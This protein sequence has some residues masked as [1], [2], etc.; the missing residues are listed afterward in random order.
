MAE[1]KPQSLRKSTVKSRKS[2]TKQSKT[3]KKKQSKTDKK[4][5]SK[6]DKKKRKPIPNTDV[7]TGLNSVAKF[8]FIQSI[9]SG[10]ASA[11]RDQI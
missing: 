7:D 1:D 9:I 6:T 11:I 10:I 2:Q 5:Q 4:K 8:F 3:D